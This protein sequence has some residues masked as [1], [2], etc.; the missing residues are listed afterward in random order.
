M[1]D[2]YIDELKFCVT[3]KDVYKLMEGK[4]YVDSNNSSFEDSQ[5]SLISRN[6]A[7]MNTNFELKG[8][9]GLALRVL[10]FL[11][12]DGKLNGKPLGS[13][14]TRYV[15]QLR[16]VLRE[17]SEIK[18][19]I[20]SFHEI[21]LNFIKLYLNIKKNESPILIK[22]RLL[23]F[24]EWIAFAN[25]YLPPF[26][27]LNINIFSASDEFKQ[28]E[29]KA[30]IQR[31]ERGIKE[32]I[33]KSDD[34]YSFI[35]LKKILKSAIDDISHLYEDALQITDIVVKSKNNKIVKNSHEFLFNYFVKTKYKMKSK[36]LTDIQELCIKQ[37]NSGLNSSSI[38]GFKSILTNFVDNMEAACAIVILFTT[39]MRSGELVSLNRNL[40]IVENEYLSLERL[41]FKTASH[42][43]GDELEIPIPK[44]TKTALI[45]LSK[46]TEIKE[47]KKN[48]QMIVTSIKSLVVNPSS[49]IVRKLLIK[50]VN[51]VGIDTCP[52]VHQLR[53]AMAFLIAYSDDK[54]GLE[55]AKVFL[56]HKSIMMTLH[57]LGHYNLI[58][59]NAILEL[60]EKESKTL[61][62]KIVNEIKDGRKIYGEKGDK[63]IGN[64]HFLGSYSDDLADLLQKSLIELIKSGKLAI[65]QTPVCIC[66]H[67]LTKIDEMSCQRGLNINNFLGARPIKSRC[68][69]ENCVNSLFTESA[70]RKL[71]ENDIDL[72]LRERLMKN[73]YFADS[74]GFDNDPYQKIINKYDKDQKKLI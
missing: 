24:I 64:H 11:K 52:R 54:S 40:K 42:N 66:I 32:L 58:L 46:I 57:Y 53:H 14:T 62:E 17:F 34:L 10:T 23:K 71:K 60:Q 16:F 4:I 15:S 49:G 18:P 65:L 7:Y 2:N 55:L 20:K 1:H 31:E 35:K 38:K 48:G 45:L 28:L 61:V 67:D 12:L 72:E 3:S 6:K 73:T 74:G 27:R 33:K 51:K 25:K 26:L 37:H 9:Y 13:G 39:G 22:E 47:G 21:D 68:S 29:N 8:M 69:A 30:K 59:K 19:D 50:Y 70:V 56:G 36:E 41:V 63:L 44:I 43:N 5:I